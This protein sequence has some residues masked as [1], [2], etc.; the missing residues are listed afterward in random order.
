[1]VWNWTREDAEIGASPPNQTRAVERRS[2][3]KS[4]FPLES[5]NR[6][7]SRGK[8]HHR[9]AVHVGHEMLARQFHFDAD[10]VVP[11]D[12]VLNEVTRRGCRHT[13]A[14]CDRRKLPFR[15][16]QVNTVG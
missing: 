13:G 10:R 2:S 14:G 9:V 15:D 11:L 3:A 1:M 5:R 4:S 7:R 16:Q 12:G 8:R 6:T